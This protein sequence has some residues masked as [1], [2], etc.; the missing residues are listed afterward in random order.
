MF[1]FSFEGHRSASCNDTIDILDVAFGFDI[2]HPT[3]EALLVEFE[4]LTGREVGV[5]STEIKGLIKP[6]ATAPGEI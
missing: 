2:D 6:G 5:H 1:G 3:P 4:R